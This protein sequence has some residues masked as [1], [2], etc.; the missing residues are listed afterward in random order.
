MQLK[1]LCVL[2]NLTLLTVFFMSFSIAI[3]LHFAVVCK[4]YMIK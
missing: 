1:F 3:S 2:T 4:G